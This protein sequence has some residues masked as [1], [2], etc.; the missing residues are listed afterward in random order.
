MG[1][2]RHLTTDGFTARG[3]QDHHR[4]RNRDDNDDDPSLR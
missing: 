3:R 1:G 2:L 4:D